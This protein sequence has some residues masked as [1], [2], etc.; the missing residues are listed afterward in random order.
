[1]SFCL[2]AGSMGIDVKNDFRHCRIKGGP[3]ANDQGNFQKYLDQQGYYR[4]IDALRILE[5]KATAGKDTALINRASRESQRLYDLKE[6]LLLQWVAEHPNSLVSA[7]FLQMICRQ[8]LIRREPF[9]D[10]LTSS[11]K[12]NEY[13]QELQQSIDGHN[14]TRPGKTAPDFSQADTSGNNISL[15]DFRGKYVLIDFWA[16]WCVPCRAENP[17]LVAA[18]NKY[19]DKG[20]TIIGVSLD[21]KRDKW[22]EAI[23]KDG[24][25]WIH[26]SDLRFWKNAIAV[27]YNIHSVPDNFLLDP[28]GK[29][30]ARNLRGN[31]LE[32]EL[33]ALLQ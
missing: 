7:F 15:Q 33:A 16:S 21:E 30:I 25:P 3:V 29:I 10:K 31:R 32:K 6:D 2:E 20:F 8:P 19:K 28:Q 13:G 27:Q 22:V 24:L 17:T 11:A 26:V 12:N 5:K 14:A 4:Q 9:F 1:M 18:Y 23:V